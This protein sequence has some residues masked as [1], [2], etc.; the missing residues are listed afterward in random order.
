VPHLIAIS[1]S[2]YWIFQ[3]LPETRWRL[4]KERMLLFFG[5]IGVTFI[6]LS[7]TILLPETWHQMGLFAGQKRLGHDGLRIHGPALQARWSDWLRG[8]PWYFYLVFTWVNYRC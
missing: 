3:N 8:T 2:Y 7:P 1:V 6:V 4:G 5:I